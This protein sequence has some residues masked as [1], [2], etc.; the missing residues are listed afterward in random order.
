MAKDDPTYYAWSQIAHGVDPSGS[1][2]T[3]EPGD[4]VTAK[5]LGLDKAGFQQLVDTYAIR[6]V[7]FPPLPD[8]YPDSPQRWWEDQLRKTDGDI[9]A[10][11]ELGAAPGYTSLSDPPPLPPG[12]E[13]AKSAEELEADAKEAEEAAQKQAEL[14]RLAEIGRKA[15]EE[16][17]KQQTTEKK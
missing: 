13:P 1:L 15:E 11:I 2:I 8:N 7:P 3:C 9:V 17:A 12:I 5:S 6:E 10:A 4:E 16:A 14:E